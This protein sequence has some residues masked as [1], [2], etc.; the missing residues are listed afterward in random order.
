MKK[1]HQFEEIGSFGRQLLFV[2]SYINRKIKHLKMY[3][4]QSD[5]RPAV[6]CLKRSKQ[7]LYNKHDGLT[8][9]SVFIISLCV[10]RI[11]TILVNA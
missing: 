9:P 11:Y 3:L 7:D 4:T 1:F 5:L 6:T 8:R 2:T 10:S